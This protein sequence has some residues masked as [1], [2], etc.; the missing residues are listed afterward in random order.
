MGCQDAQDI[1]VS[2]SNLDEDIEMTLIKFVGD[3]KLGGIANL[4]GDWIQ[5]RSCQTGGMVQ[6]EGDEI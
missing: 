1:N 6:I 2:I 4:S 3:M 5:K